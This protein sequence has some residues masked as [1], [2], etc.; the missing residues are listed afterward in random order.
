MCNVAM[1]KVCPRTYL[2][3]TLLRSPGAQPIHQGPPYCSE[4]VPS[5][6]SSPRPNHIPLCPV[7]EEEEDEVN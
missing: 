4:A 5:N 3:P 6:C 7:T 1:L 2:I